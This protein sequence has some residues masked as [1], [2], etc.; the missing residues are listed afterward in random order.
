MIYHTLYRG[1]LPAKKYKFGCTADGDVYLKSV[2]KSFMVAENA[3]Y[4]YIVTQNAEIKNKKADSEEYKV[5]GNIPKGTKV[6]RLSM[7]ESWRNGKAEM[8][9]VICDGKSGHI[10]CDYAEE[11][12]D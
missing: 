12:E 1:Y 5:T 6:I 11:I 9:Y 4:D 8:Y 10:S 3:E 7:Y 2:D